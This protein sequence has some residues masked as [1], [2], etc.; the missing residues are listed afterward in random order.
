MDWINNVANLLP[1]LLCLGAKIV[2][3]NPVIGLFSGLAAGIALE[4]VADALNLDCTTT[5]VHEI[6]SNEFIEI[7]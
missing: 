7:L 6:N 3:S 4:T 1:S 5:I 2:G